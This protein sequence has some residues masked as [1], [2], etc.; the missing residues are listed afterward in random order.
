MGPRTIASPPSAP[1]TMPFTVIQGFPLR[2]AILGHYAPTN[3]VVPDVKVSVTLDDPDGKLKAAF[4]ADP[5]LQQQM[6][7]RLIP[8]LREDLAK[9]MASVVAATELNMADAHKVKR[10]DR[11]KAHS[12]GLAARLEAVKPQILPKIEGAA[13]AVIADLAAKRKDYTRYKV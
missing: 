8:L 1:P 12:A 9:L 5:M 4:L 6:T 11:A 2:N 7:D 10:E 3:V 13:A